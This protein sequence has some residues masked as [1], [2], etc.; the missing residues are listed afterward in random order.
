RFTRQRHKVA[1]GKLAIKGLELGKLANLI[2]GVAFAGA[3][4]TGS[5][6]ADVDM[7]S[8]PLDS[9]KTAD[10]TVVLKQLE[11]GRDGHH[12]ELAE[13]SGKIALKNDELTV[14]D[15]HLAGRTASGLRASLAVGGAVHHAT[16]TADLDL[17]VRVEPLELS[18]L[19]ADIK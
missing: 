1:S 5:L 16:T 11:V 4:P 6:S 10:V 3:P 18:K 8:L 13:P 9:L 15:L 14:P 7:T 2:P 17:G 12:A 19:S